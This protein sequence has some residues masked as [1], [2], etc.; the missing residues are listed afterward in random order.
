MV[1]KADG[2]SAATISK[3]KDYFE[4][5]REEDI[6][7]EIRRLAPIDV[8]TAQYVDRSS[9]LDAY[10]RT[11]IAGFFATDAQ[12]EH[13]LPWPASRDFISEL[14]HSDDPNGPIVE[15]GGSEK[16]YYESVFYFMRERSFFTTKEGFIGLAPK[17]AR[18]GDVVCVLLGCSS[19]LVLRPIES[20]Y[21]VVGECYVE[22]MMRG[23]L[24]L[25]PLPAN[26]R[27]G[28]WLNGS[29]HES[30]SF[31]F[32]NT[33]TGE[34]DL[35]DPRLV[36]IAKKGE[37]VELQKIGSAYLH[38]MLTLQR[39]KGMGVIVTSFELV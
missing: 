16:A 31:E 10:C 38:P 5:D 14:L 34:R 20:K 2:V 13:R 7:A 3:T 24:L 1:L 35:K 39:L 36:T 32:T 9:L 18:T 15:P 21:Q 11:L 26:Y 29:N 19:P 12:D 27:P 30:S 37:V 4:S 6:R 25:G 17:A 28:P 33:D 22:G 8:L 23:E